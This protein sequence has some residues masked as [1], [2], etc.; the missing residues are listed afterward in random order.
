MSRNIKGI[1]VSDLTE[2]NAGLELK[3]LGHEIALHDE[4]YH[5]NDA[6]VISDSEYDDLLRELITIEKND[7]KEYPIRIFNSDGIEVSAC[8]IDLTCM[9]KIFS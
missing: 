4:A 8:G 3:N 6:P 1:P 5:R 2:V 7:G 9:E